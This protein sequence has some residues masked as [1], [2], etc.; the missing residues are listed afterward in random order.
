MRLYTPKCCRCFVPDLFLF[1][2]KCQLN[3]MPSDS[4]HLTER[5]ID[6]LEQ[7]ESGLTYQEIAEALFISENT[8]RT[9]IRHIYKKLGASNRTHALNKWRKLL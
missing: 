2:T 3:K 1:T 5:E 4:P 8:V 6:I 9:H 7:L